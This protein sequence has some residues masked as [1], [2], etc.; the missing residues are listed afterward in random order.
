M[1]TL[2]LLFI[3]LVQGLGACSP[4]PSPPHAPTANRTVNCRAGEGRVLYDLGQEV[5]QLVLWRL[6]HPEL[7]EGLS[8][9]TPCEEVLDLLPGLDLTGRFA[10]H[11]YLAQGAFRTCFCEGF[12]ER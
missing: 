6:Q 11:Q 3:V 4:G 5:R 12:S 10:S 7:R 9:E 2:I 8:S 1:A